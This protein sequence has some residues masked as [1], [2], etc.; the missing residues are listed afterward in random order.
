MNI[1][2]TVIQLMARRIQKCTTALL[3]Q[4]NLI[5][6]AKAVHKEQTVACQ[7]I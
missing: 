1:A 2:A 7:N 4:R 6:H 3:A 5:K